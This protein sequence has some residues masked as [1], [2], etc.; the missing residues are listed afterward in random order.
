VVCDWLVGL[1]GLPEHYRHARGAGGGAIHDAAS[2]STFVA[3]VAARHDAT[4]GDP[5]ELPGLRAYASVDAHSS[6]EKGLRLAG[7]AAS[8]LRLVAVDEQRRMRPD[9]LAAAVDADVAAG[10]RPFFIT[11]TVGTTSFMAIDPVATAGAVARRH[12]LWH[13]VDAAMAGSAAASPVLRP[14]VVDGLETADSFCFDPHKWLLAGMDCDVLYVADRRKLVA[15]MSVVPEYLRNAASDTGEVVDLR[16]WGIPLGRRFRSLKL[17]FVLRTYGADGLA[18]L[19]E[20]GHRLS[21]DLGERVAAHPS[22]DPVAPAQ[23]ALVT[24]AHRDGDAATQRLID[25]VNATGAQVTHTRL[26]GRL[27]LR[28]STGQARTTARHVDAVWAAIHDAT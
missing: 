2:T 7:L 24:L 14:M 28:V 13:H 11:S 6:V 5:A 26:D 22:L 3:A 4:G 19:V 27:V 9:A 12:G 10:H 20:R 17:W 25:A 21:V 23:L 15:A 1:L 18:A 16:D 8:Q